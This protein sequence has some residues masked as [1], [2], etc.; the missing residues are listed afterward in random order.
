MAEAPLPGVRGLVFVGFPLHAAGR[1]STAR[2]THLTAAGVP[3]LFLQ[4]TRDTLAD[5]TLLRPIVEALPQAT[6]HVVEDADHGFHVRRSSGRS[7]AEVLDE[8]A[9]VT[10][11]WIGQAAR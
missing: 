6:M 8:L 9:D 1:P 7:D 2:G 10:E 4:G 3:L 5:L 11:A